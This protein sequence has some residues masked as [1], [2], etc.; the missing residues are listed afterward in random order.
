[1]AEDHPTVIPPGTVDVTPPTPKPKRRR[2]P[3][4]L[5]VPPVGPSEEEISPEIQRTNELLK[6]LMDDCTT[7]VIKVA[8]CDCNHKA[9][10][11]VYRKGQ[12]IAKVI[13]ELQELRGK[14]A[15]PDQG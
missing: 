10:C 12:M 5:P 15:V 14:G 1:M 2:G 9:D 3:T 7:L 8:A 11:E 6:Q 13:D 4:Q